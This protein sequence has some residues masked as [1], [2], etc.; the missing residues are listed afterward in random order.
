MH[1]SFLIYSNKVSST[2]FEQSNSSSAGSY[3]VCSIRYLSCIYVDWLLA[4]SEWNTCWSLLNKYITIHD[5][6]SCESYYC[7][8]WVNPRLLD[9]MCRRFGTLC[10]IYT[11][12][13]RSLQHLY[14]DLLRAGRSEDRTPVE[15]EIS[16]TH[17]D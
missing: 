3:C 17:V 2:C 12:G 9:F 7:F 5:P 1:F 6:E 15:G 8:F 11:G 4:R 16:R 13:L 14:S 10:F